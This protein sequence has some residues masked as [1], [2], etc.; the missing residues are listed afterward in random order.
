VLALF[1]FF[2]SFLG[3]AAAFLGEAFLGEAAAFLGEAFSFFSVSFFSVFFLGDFSAFSAGSASAFSFFVTFFL[4]DSFFSVVLA[5]FFGDS[6]LAGE[7]EADLLV[8]F[9]A[10]EAERFLGCLSMN[11]LASSA[12]FPFLAGEAWPWLLVFLVVEAA[13]F[14]SFSMVGINKS[15]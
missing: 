5:F 9:L 13:G 2:V 4:G 3:E 6:F 11:L 7:A 14:F 12:S 1:N 8:A 15:V 10:G